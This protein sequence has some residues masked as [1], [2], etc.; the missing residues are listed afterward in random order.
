MSSRRMR[1]RTTLIKNWRETERD[2]DEVGLD[3]D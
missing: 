1:S 2:Y 3:L